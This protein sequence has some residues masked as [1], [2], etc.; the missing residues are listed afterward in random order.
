MSILNLKLDLDPYI[1]VDPGTM[2]RLSQSVTQ[3]GYVVSG[4]S[5]NNRL[6][7]IIELPGHPS[8]ITITSMFGG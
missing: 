5:P 4:I 7:E 6:V 3:F 2:S 1:N 8:F